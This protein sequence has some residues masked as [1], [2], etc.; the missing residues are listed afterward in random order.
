MT[1]PG[2]RIDYDPTVPEFPHVLFGP[3]GRLGRYHS[4]PIAVRSAG[5]AAK[6]N[7]ALGYISYTGLKHWSAPVLITRIPKVT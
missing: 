2:Y 4:L 7:A 5:T 1:T 6:G 3:D